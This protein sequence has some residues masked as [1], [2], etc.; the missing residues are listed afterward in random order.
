MD[1]G[2]PCARYTYT[3]RTKV[4][5]YMSCQQVSPLLA[6]K[7]PRKGPYDSQSSLCVVDVSLTRHALLGFRL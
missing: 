5:R 4:E 1:Y 7:G 3:N 6:C 2:S